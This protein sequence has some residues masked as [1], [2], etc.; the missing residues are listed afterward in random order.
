[1]G[2]VIDAIAIVVIAVTVFLSARHGFVRTL[3][4]VVG[5]IA[6]FMLA[7][8]ISSP[9]ATLTYNKVLEPPMISAVQSAADEGAQSAVDALWDAM[10]SFIT[11]NGEALGITHDGISDKLGSAGSSNQMADA[12]KDTSRTMVM[13][14]A[15]SLLSMLYSTIVFVLLLILVKFI[16][17]GIN[18][19]FSFS[20]IGKANRVMGGA[21]GV[22]KGTLIAVAVVMV[23]R[24]IISAT[25]GFW[26]FGPNIIESSYFCRFLTTVF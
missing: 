17:I 11:E 2:I 16:A 22:V 24:L 7:Y 15:V 18:K 26:I 12:I 20:I 23:I 25:G 4:E 9:L 5:F 8:G 21:L 10:P 1:M 14:I 13:P 19:L 6:A 3:I